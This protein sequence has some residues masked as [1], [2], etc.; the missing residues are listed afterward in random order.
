MSNASLDARAV[1]ARP[2]P[3]QQWSAA[4]LRSLLAGGAL[5]S[6]GGPR[7]LQDPLSFR[8]ASQIHGSLQ[9]ALALLEAALVP[10]LSGAAVNPLVIV[11]DDELISTGN[12]HVPALALALDATAIAIAQVAAAASERPAR[13]AT[14]RLSGLPANLTRLGPT[15]SG[16]AVLQKT[17]QSLTVEIRHLAAPLAFDSH[18]GAD[19]VEDDSTNTVQAALRVRDQLERFRRLVALELVSAAQA[20][21]LASPGSLGAGTG[22]AYACVREL[23]APLVDD[24]PLGVDVERVAGEALMNG[25]L[26]TRV[27]AA[28][29]R[30]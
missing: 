23:V 27:D 24:R 17:A 12:F 8:C 28:L 11:A 7:R 3:G 1:A 6:P 25:H 21:D 29:A 13:L 5:A 30:A 10:E 19:G 20:I 16:V 26:L 22:A 9:T 18:I 15:R 4:G 14:E 2:A